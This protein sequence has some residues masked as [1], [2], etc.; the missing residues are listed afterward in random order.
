MRLIEVTKRYQGQTVLDRIDVSFP[1]GRLSLITGPSGSGKTTL[2]HLAAGLAVPD[3]GRVE[4]GDRAVSELSGRER[5]RF[6]AGV[7]VAFQRSGL[8]GGLTA[9][10]NITVGHRL[11]GR[12]VDPSWVD[13]LTDLLGVAAVLDLRASRL[14]GGQAQRVA[15]VRALAHQPP[16]LFADEPTASL[17][18][19]GTD[20]V[21][22]LLRRL[23]HDHAITVLLVSHDQTAPHHADE[24]F[25]LAD[26]HLSPAAS[27][28]HRRESLA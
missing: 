21:H 23:S 12:A 6:R 1:P 17:D 2:L 5:A 8:L 7:G 22:E 27:A 26:G 13:H 4:V 19:H 3:S 11:T 25:A 16:V 14:S 15:L 18:S 9:R 10:E 28:R 24:V 20:Q